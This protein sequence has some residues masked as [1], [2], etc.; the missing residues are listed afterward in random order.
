MK[1]KTAEEKE[2]IIKEI[3]KLG[4]VEGCRKHNLSAS[5][6]YT[7]YRQ[8][9]SHGIKGLKAYSKNDQKDIKR[10]EKENALLKELLVSKEL[11][12]QMQADLIKKKMQQWKTKES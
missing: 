3:E 2:K 1:R 9:E 10:L 5:T 6:Y 4:I 12:I 7:W 8:Y 11:Q